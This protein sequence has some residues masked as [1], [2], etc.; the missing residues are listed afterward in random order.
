MHGIKRRASEGESGQRSFDWKIR[1]SPVLAAA[2][3]AVATRHEATLCSPVACQPPVLA[4]APIGSSVRQWRCS[5][6][7]FHWPPPWWRMQRFPDV[8]RVD[9]DRVGMGFSTSERRLFPDVLSPDGL[10]RHPLGAR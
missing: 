7:T 10:S 9:D 5:Q 2:T 3:V 8:P 4:L 1:P 6:E